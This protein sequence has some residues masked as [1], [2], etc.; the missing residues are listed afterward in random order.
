MSLPPEFD[1]VLAALLDVTDRDS[2]VLAVKQAQYLMER[3][4]LARK[5]A[6]QGMIGSFLLLESLTETMMTTWRTRLAVPLAGYS[7][8]RVLNGQSPR[9]SLWIVGR[10]V[11]VRL[12]R[13]VYLPLI[14]KVEELAQGLR[15]DPKDIPATGRNHWYKTLRHNWRMNLI[16]DLDDAMIAGV[17][18][19]QESMDLYPDASLKWEQKTVRRWMQQ[20]LK[21]MPLRKR[22]PKN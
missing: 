19:A 8:C 22:V 2:L 13:R 15:P 7:G 11:S 12:V 3:D 10:E 6:Q 17:K 20:Y 16:R 9:N 14:V 1:A 18:S 4:R 21:L 5:A